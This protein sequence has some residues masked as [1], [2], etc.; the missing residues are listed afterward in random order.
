MIEA[1]PGKLRRLLLPVVSPAMVAEGI[2]RREGEC[3]GCGACCQLGGMRCPFL[4]DDG[5]LRTHCA[6]YEVRPRSCRLFP[7]S[8]ADL[9]EVKGRC[10]ILLRGD[11]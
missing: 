4:V 9:D 10:S 8:V 11:W 1:V 5:P 2:A 3:N 7:F 6:I